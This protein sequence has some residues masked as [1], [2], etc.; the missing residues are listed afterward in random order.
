MIAV[1]VWSMLPARSAPLTFGSPSLPLPSSNARHPASVPAR[2]ARPVAPA[3]APAR[4]MR[5]PQAPLWNLQT[6]QLES[7][8]LDKY[9][10]TPFCDSAFRGEIRHT[11]APSRVIYGTL[12]YLS[13]ARKNRLR[14][15]HS[16]LFSLFLDFALIILV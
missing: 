7:H 11:S 13:E 14:V 8:D 16:F 12:A 6:S 2:Y 3:T 5:S 15:A 1:A 10:T 9:C 4:C